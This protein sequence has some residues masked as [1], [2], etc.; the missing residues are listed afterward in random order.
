MNFPQ[1]FR[2]KPYVFSM[3]YVFFITYVMCSSFGVIFTAD[4]KCQILVACDLKSQFVFAVICNRW[5]TCGDYVL[6][7]TY[8]LTLCCFCIVIYNEYGNSTFVY[9]NLQQIG[10]AVRCCCN[11]QQFMMLPTLL[12]VH[13][14]A[15]RD[16]K[17]QFSSHS[18]L[19]WFQQQFKRAYCILQLFCM[20]AAKQRQYKMRG[21]V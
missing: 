8:T 13:I 12:A 4:L 15:T 10:A 20:C 11:F 7:F 14:V 19:Q 18:I 6:Y 16:L 9:C 17:S 5:D 3:V 1:L 21:C 2:S